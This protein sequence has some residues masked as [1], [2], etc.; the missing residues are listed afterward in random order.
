[1]SV[2]FLKTINPSSPAE[3]PKKDCLNHKM[4]KEHRK[5]CEHYDEVTLKFE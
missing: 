3:N 5:N 4:S 2:C 1:M